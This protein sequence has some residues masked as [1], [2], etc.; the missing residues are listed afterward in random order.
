MRIL[1]NRQLLRD[2]DAARAAVMAREQ[3]MSTGMQYG[4][5]IPHGRT[6]AVDRLV[7]AIGLKKGGVDFD[8][9]DGKP[10]SIFVLA[11]SPEKSSAPQMQFMSMIS[12]ILDTDG[13]EAL[14]ACETPEEMFAVLVGED[15]SRRV[16]G[17]HGVSAVGRAMRA[18]AEKLKDKLRRD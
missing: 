18:I 13:R 11:L 12:Q 8:S 1:Q 6:D 9:I 4:I 14:L 5:A 17:E 10:C 7:C 2:F 16:L 3:S 15:M